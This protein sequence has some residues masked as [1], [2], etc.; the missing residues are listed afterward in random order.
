MT[1]VELVC[2][3]HAG[4]GATSFNLLRR[5]LS[6]AGANINITAVELPGHGVRCREQ[7]FV[8]AYACARSLVDELAVP[9][10]R[11]HVLLGHS[12]GALLA[13]L[14]AQQRIDQGLRPPAAVIVVAAQAPHLNS[15]FEDI[16][17]TH[18]QDLATDLVAYGGLPA[19]VL[20]RPEWL[21]VLMPVIRDDLRMCRSYR[22][23]GEP[24]LPCALHIFGAQCDPLV[25]FD[26]LD[27]W[28]DYSMLPQPIRLFAGN[29]FLFRPSNPELVQAISHI[30]E[31]ALSIGELVR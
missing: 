22:Q 19:E 25:P 9:L 20:A 27:A 26:A 16:D 29:H 24:P 6:S 18:D 5:D 13:Y 8:D 28:S 3:P 15:Q 30:T 17:A 4:G 11:P 31:T 7:R 2:F 14:V 12:M 10:S 21:D 1:P 23:S